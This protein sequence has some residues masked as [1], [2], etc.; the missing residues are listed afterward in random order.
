MRPDD[1]RLVLKDGSDVE[2]EYLVV[3]P[4]CQL[5]FDMIKGAAEAIEDEDCPVGSIYTLKGAYKTARLKEEFKGGNAIFTLPTMPIKCGG[6]PQKIMYLCEEHFRTNKVRDQTTVKWHT[7]VG[8]MF[9][10]CK[11]FADALAPIAASK[12]IEITYKS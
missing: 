5:R 7:T 1:N 8:D 10:N 12:D 3:S 11:K 9:P 6:A 4:G 2:Y